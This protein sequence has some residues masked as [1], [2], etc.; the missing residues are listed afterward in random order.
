M[1]TI[2]PIVIS[3]CRWNDIEI[4]NCGLFISLLYVILIFD[5]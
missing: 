3:N 2:L 4:V 5:Y 1:K